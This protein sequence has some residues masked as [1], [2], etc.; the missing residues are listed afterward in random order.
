ML[1]LANPA[2]AEQ[3]PSTAPERA[4][5]WVLAA[6]VVL[7][8]AATAPVVFNPA[9]Q[10]LYATS[11]DSVSIANWARQATWRE[12]LS[13]WYSTW[14]QADSFYYRPLSSSVLWLEY[15]LFGWNFQAFTVVSWLLHG[16]N[17]ALLAALAGRLL[18]DRG[19]TAVWA[20]V[21]VGL[22]NARL[23]PP[24]PY[25]KRAPVAAGIVI[26]WPAQTDQLSLAASLASLLLLDRYLL[27]GRRRDGWAALAAYGAALLC[28]EMS[29]CVPLLAALLI[30]YR[31]A[32][33][34][35]AL[36]LVYLA[37]AVLF[38][39]VRQAAVPYAWGPDLRKLLQPSYLALKA[40]WYAEANLLGYILPSAAGEGWLLVAAA[41]ALAAVYAL[42]RLRA[43]VVW[44]ILAAVLLAALV[45]HLLGG[46]F[47]LLTMPRELYG[48]LLALLFLLGLLVLVRLGDGRTWTLV[49]MV[50]AVHLPI[51]HLTGPHYW[52]WPAAFWAL[53]HARLL[54]L[55]WQRLEEVMRRP[56]FAAAP[57][58]LPS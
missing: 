2:Q 46:N 19:W 22:F 41:A 30:V 50:V 20:L 45:A 23:G 9:L 33:K 55:A 6:A 36:L 25:W 48:L 44:M 27:A 56:P 32:A 11:P 14:I 57:A 1:A 38:V 24:G 17:A 43:S 21:A 13:W 28:K 10:Q 49:G 18:R 47:A 12:A 16:L 54:S 31:R 52:Y 3:Q 35:G 26:W 5:A 51:L 58:P 34:A 39:F 37:V 53:L 8:L 4:Q 42:W 15:L 7:S 40:A 29:L